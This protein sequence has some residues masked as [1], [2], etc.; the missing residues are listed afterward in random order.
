MLPQQQ[1]SQAQSQQLPQSQQ[2]A[3]PTQD[4]EGDGQLE[5]EKL[6]LTEDPKELLAVSGFTET[7]AAAPPAEEQEPEEPL[8]VSHPDSQDS[9]ASSN[10]QL[11]QTVLGTLYGR[12]VQATSGAA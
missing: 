4:D 2:R 9:R 11:V 12:I 10:A 6:L 7:E 3:R 1:Q 8:E 5:R